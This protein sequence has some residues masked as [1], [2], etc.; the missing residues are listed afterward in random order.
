MH[1][2]FHHALIAIAAVAGVSRQ[3]KAVLTFNVDTA[4]WPN[5]AQRQAAVDAMQ[6]V[7]NRYNAYGDFGDHNVY[8]YYNAGIPTAQSNYLGSIGFGG[9]YPNERVAMHELGHYL[10]SGTYGT[11]WDGARSEGMIDQF[12]GIEAFLQG[13]TQHFWP[14]GLNYDDEGAEINKQ[15]QVAMIY[16][17]RAD[18]GIGSTANPGIAAKPLIDMLAGVLNL[19]ES[20]AAAAPLEAA[21]Y[22]STQHRPDVALHFSKDGFGLHLTEVGSTLWR[23]RLGFRD[24]LRASPEL[25]REY[26]R[27]KLR[28]SAEAAYP[29]TYTGGKRAFVH[30]VLLGAGIDFAWR[31]EVPETSASP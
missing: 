7:V 24:A 27:L 20:R 17:E 15:R 6:S 3:T 11:P 9:T 30:R 25:Q 29:R 31:D 28:L 13:D 8:V 23:E 14:Y 21:G 2:K 26:E 5:A 10:G 19:E 22:E 1:K 12:D 16:A 4:G 18:M